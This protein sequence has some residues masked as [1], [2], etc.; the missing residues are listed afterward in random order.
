MTNSD[1]TTGTANPYFRVWNCLAGTKLP[2]TSDVVIHTELARGGT[3]SIAR[4]SSR[5]ESNQAS[6]NDTEVKMEVKRKPGIDEFE[7]D[8]HGEEEQDGRDEYNSG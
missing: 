1:T 2:T 8:Y 6:T 4:R 3:S 5:A 7:D